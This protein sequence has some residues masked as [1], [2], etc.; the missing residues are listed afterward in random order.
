MDDAMIQRALQSYGAANTP[1]NIAQLT[2]FMASNPAAM[3]H[4]AMGMRG[5]VN[6]DNTDLL[7]PLLEKLVAA[8]AGR[9]GAAVDTE[10]PVV[11]NGNGA[12]APQARVAPAPRLSD[13]NREATGRPLQPGGIPGDLN[14]PGTP[15]APADSGSSWLD[16][17]LLTLI[18]GYAAAAARPTAAGPPARIAG[19]QSTPVDPDVQ[20]RLA[21]PEAPRQLTGPPDQKQI[22]GPPDQKR[23][24]AP[25]G[26]LT[27]QR[28]PAQSSS[29][30]A[31]YY[32]HPEEQG[33][34]SA[35]EA[36]N[37]SRARLKNAARQF[38]K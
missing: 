33:V 30:D 15:P 12:P 21:G 11:A 37:A 2:R 16:D 34:P 14:A 38:R 25:Q 29:G 31:R 9:S 6:D 19:P 27:D 8:S 10:P 32:M 20:R 7:G 13:P 22:T 17:L 23:L 36:A 24:P 35:T 1:A 18:P 4:R 5:S 26:K 3:E 28:E